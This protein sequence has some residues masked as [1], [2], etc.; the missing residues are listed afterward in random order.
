VTT[1]DWK[2]VT[3]HLQHPQEFNPGIEMKPD[4]LRLTLL[5]N[6]NKL[7]CYIQLYSTFLQFSSRSNQDFKLYYLQMLAFS[8]ISH[9]II[10]T[11]Q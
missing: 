1:T 3:N 10:K 4:L 9:T 7:E 11:K 6:N 5:A 2:I 8:L